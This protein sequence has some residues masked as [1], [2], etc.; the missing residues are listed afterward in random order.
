MCE[1]Y[2][3]SDD[4]CRES[5]VS[6]IGEGDSLIYGRV[7]HDRCNRAEYLFVVT[8]DC[9]CDISEDRRCIE[10][11][12]SFDTF[13]TLDES[14]PCRDRTCDLCIHIIER[15]FIHEWLE[16][17]FLIHRISEDERFEC[18]FI[19][20]EELL[21]HHIWYE[22]SLGCIA[23]LTTIASTTC[24]CECDDLLD[25]RSREYD[26]CIIASEFEDTALEVLACESSNSTSC[27]LAASQID[28]ADI[29]MSNDSLTHRGWNEEV[30]VYSLR[31]SSL[32]KKSLDTF[33]DHRNIG[34]VLVDLCIAGE[35]IGHSSAEELIEWKIPRRNTI[36]DTYWIIHLEDLES[37]SLIGTRGEYR[38]KIIRK[39]PDEIRSFLESCFCVFIEHTHLDGLESGTI[40]DISF[41]C[42]C[43]REKKSLLLKTWDVTP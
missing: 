19:L 38:F 43:E 41:E 42:V 12:A 14:S 18:I 1:G 4:D 8:R 10:V 40:V 22:E 33:C 2:I 15:F 17:G 3:I 25:I 21:I 32:V 39:P 16:I 37:L 26:K 27:C 36:D 24:D 28:P 20:F 13:S 30:G 6:S 7:R 11:S 34:C 29:R 23:R 5:E 31:E 35:D 9:W